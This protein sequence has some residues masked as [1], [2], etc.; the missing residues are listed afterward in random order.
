MYN[1]F[2]KNINMNELRKIAEFEEKE[3]AEDFKEA[4]K[5][6]TKGIPIEAEVREW[7]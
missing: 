2:A 4:L 7:Y 6:N 5:N 3:E 1:V